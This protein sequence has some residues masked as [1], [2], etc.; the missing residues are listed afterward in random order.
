[1]SS[2]VKP[3]RTKVTLIRKGE[4][5]LPDDDGFIEGDPSYLMGMV[6]ELTKDAWAFR[7]EDA[8]RRLQRH[9]VNIQRRSVS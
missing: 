3:D 5:A 9:I 8:E 6:W 4:T 1:M 2:Q 7:G